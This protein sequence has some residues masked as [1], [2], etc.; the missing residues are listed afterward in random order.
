MKFTTLSFGCVLF[1]ALS[2]VPASGVTVINGTFDDNA[3]A[4]TVWPGYN[5]QNGVNPANPTGWTIT[6]GG[7]IN[8]VSP[9]GAG[10]D[11]FNDGASTG[12]FAFLQGETRLEQ[13]IAG[14]AVG[15]SYTL[16]LDFNARNCCTAGAGPIAD[17]YLNDVLLA[18]STDLFPAP[19]YVIPGTLA[20]GGNWYNADLPFVAGANSI[21]L[22]IRAR[23]SAGGAD[24]TLI[25]DNV[26]V[27]P[28]PSTFAAL[29]LS[30]GLLARRRR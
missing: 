20:N 30:L 28:E 23:P 11:P 21:T 18:S 6:G 26:S 12:A 5:G 9:V 24:T 8:P 14:F 29:V 25:V 3:A 1:A 17:V 27:V 19:G 15:A 2:L 4:Y 13:T 10:Q 16:S 22:S 7:G